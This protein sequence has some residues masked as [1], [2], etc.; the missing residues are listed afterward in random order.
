M[1]AVSLYG[2]ERYRR[3]PWNSARVGSHHP[4]GGGRGIWLEARSFGA[5]VSGGS[6]MASAE[7]SAHGLFADRVGCVDHEGAFGAHAASG[8]VHARRRTRGSRF[9]FGFL[10]WR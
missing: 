1:Y 2:P 8:R 3:D 6:G 10:Y 4:D 5:A 7:A 9:F